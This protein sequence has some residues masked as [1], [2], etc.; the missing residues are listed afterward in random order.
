MIA[1]LVGWIFTGGG[2][3]QMGK[4]RKTMGRGLSIEGRLN[5]ALVFFLILFILE[6]LS[7]PIKSKPSIAY[8]SVAYKKRM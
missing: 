8:K 2:N 1:H 4:I 7:F 6:M 5:T 3:E